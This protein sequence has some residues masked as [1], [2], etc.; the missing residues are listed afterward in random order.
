MTDPT[1][2]VV[3][4][5]YNR[6][7]LL[8]RAVE[9]VLDGD[10]GDL[11]LHVVD[12]GSTD[13]TPAV[14]DAYDD[15]RLTYHRLDEN[16]GANAARNHGVAAASGEYVAFLDSDDA[17][18]PSYL[19]R[20]VA[21]LEDAPD[22]YVGTY[23]SRVWYRDGERWNLTVADNDVSHDDLRRKNAVGGFSNVLVERDVFDRVGP[24]DEDLDS[25]QDYDFFLRALAPADHRLRAVPDAVVEYYCHDE[26]STRIGDDRRAKVAG[27]ARFLEKHG[28]TLT[29]AGL[30]YQR[31]QQ[32][33]THARAGDVGTARRW[34]WRGVRTDPT[35]WRNWY[36]LLASLGGRPALRAAVSLKTGLK[37]RLARAVHDPGE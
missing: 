1:V 12:D 32:G 5:T 30:A 16:A 27:R 17:Y 4:P 36:H 15:E 18:R 37:R 21:A 11:A 10:Y 9:S 6:A 14:V 28:E 23:A 8:G 3:V 2:S 25:C 29:R 35:G 24:L 33:M 20:C 26:G 7:A 19:V 22:R 13:E 31:Y 34:F